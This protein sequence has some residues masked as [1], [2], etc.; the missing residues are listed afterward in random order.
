VRVAGEPT[1]KGFIGFNRPVSAELLK[2]ATLHRL[3]DSVE[4]KPR[5][6]LSDVESAA[7]FVAAN[8]ILAVND[9]PHSDHPLVQSKW[10]V[11]E[12]RTNLDRKLTA[13]ML[14]AAL[15][16]PPRGQETHF[17]AAAGRAFNAIG[18]AQFAER[19][20]RAVAVREVTDRFHQCSGPCDS[21]VHEL[22][23]SK[24]TQVSQLD[25]CPH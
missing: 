24:G 22:K 4:H 6:G 5:G 16:Q 10:T 18:P 23:C 20:E 15:P 2:A 8:S 19:D 7:Y 11:L 17:L 3:A 21:V 13:I 12:D 1:N 9:L 25:Y 14:L